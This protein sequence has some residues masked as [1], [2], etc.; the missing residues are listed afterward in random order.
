VRDT[1]GEAGGTEEAMRGRGSVEAEGKGDSTRADGDN[2]AGVAAG[3]L[4]AKD[5]VLAVEDS[6][7]TVDDGT[8]KGV[9][10]RGSNICE[11][12]EFSV[13]EEEEELTF[14][15]A[16]GKVNSS[17]TTSRDIYNL[18]VGIWRHL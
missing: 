5:D 13:R 8:C 15:A 12:E 14:Y 17:K 3:V 9:S 7:V 6:V 1:G 11:G 18:P 4:A 16:K 2:S 10:E